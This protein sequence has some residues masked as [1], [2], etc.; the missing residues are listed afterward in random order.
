MLSLYQRDAKNERIVW[1]I[2]SSQDHA[3]VA[4]CRLN[5]AARCGRLIQLDAGSRLPS[6]RSEAVPSM[7]PSF[8]C[9]RGRLSSRTKYLACA[10]MERVGPKANFMRQSQGY[11][12]A[13]CPL[14]VKIRHV[15][16]KTPCPLT[17]ESDTRCVHSNVRLEA[18]RSCAEGPFELKKNP[19]TN[20]PGSFFTA[21]D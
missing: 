16:C 6:S 7:R 3:T 21:L 17:P 8:G 19:G 2:V 10:R 4:F 15:Q 9:S 12:H 18:R 1:A 11:L 14:W 20:V 5:Q 13:A